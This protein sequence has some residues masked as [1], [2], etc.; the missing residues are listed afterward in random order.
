MK[1]QKPAAKRQRPK[2][3]YRFT[4]QDCQR[5]YRAAL[6]KCSQDWELYAWLFRTLRAHYRR[7]E[8]QP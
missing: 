1:R 3:R 2:G 4:R 8:D 7:K 6:E 5:G